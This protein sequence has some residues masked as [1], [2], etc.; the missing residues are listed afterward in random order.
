MLKRRPEGPA[1]EVPASRKPVERD[2]DDYNRLKAA[3]AR[4]L[5]GQ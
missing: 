4:R 5:R 2:G 3:M 1:M